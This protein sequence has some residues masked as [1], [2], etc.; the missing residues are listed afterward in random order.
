MLYGEWGSLLREVEHVE[1]DGLVASVHAAVNG[2]DHLDDC[3]AC[4][5]YLPLA[6]KPHNCQ[7]SLL[8]NAEVDDGM[9]MPGQLASDW[10]YVAHYDEFWL[11]FEIVGQSNAVP[12]LGCAFE[13]QFLD[14]CDIVVLREWRR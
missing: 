12:A 4:T 1:Y 2:A 14:G 13:F 3:I 9:M 10:D 5:Y 8:Q 7:F 6:V 11:P